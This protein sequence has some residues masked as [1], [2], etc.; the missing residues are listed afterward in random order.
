MSLNP[1]HWTFKASIAAK[2]CNLPFNILTLILDPQIVN[3]NDRMPLFPTSWLSC[4]ERYHAWVR[5]TFFYSTLNIRWYLAHIKCLQTSTCTLRTNM[6]A[7]FLV[8]LLTLNSQ[9]MAI[10]PCLCT[11]YLGTSTC[12]IQMSSL[13]AIE[14]TRGWLRRRKQKK[15]G[16]MGHFAVGLQQVIA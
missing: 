5:Q 10:E 7:K 12:T 9:T 3:C 4:D 15:R 2:T 6:D 13:G 8:C 16:S 11:L 1:M 14:N